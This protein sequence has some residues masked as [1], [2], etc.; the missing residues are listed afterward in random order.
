MQPN[1]RTRYEPAETEIPAFCHGG[2]RAFVV[3][4]LQIF[5]FTRIAWR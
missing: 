2:A 4:L 3:S 5:D 1:E